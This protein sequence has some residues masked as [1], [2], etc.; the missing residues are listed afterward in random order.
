[1]KR[2][3]F[4]VVIILVVNVYLL[5]SEPR[6]VIAWYG[7]GIVSWLILKLIKRFEK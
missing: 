5:F 1:M 4:Y 7:I 3:V 6:I 2:A